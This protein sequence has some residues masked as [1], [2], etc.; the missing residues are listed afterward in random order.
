MRRGRRPVLPRG[1]E[2]EEIVD[3]AGDAWDLVETRQLEDPS[4]PPP[5][6]WARPTVYRLVRMPVSS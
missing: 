3:L 6:R 5:I 2:K 4:M 1:M